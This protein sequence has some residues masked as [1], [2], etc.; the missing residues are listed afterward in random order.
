MKSFKE[1]L[2]ENDYP[3]YYWTQGMTR[4]VAYFK[5]KVE[6]DEYDRKHPNHDYIYRKENDKPDLSI[7]NVDNNI[8]QKLTKEEEAKLFEIPKT[9]EEQKKKIEKIDE[10]LKDLKN[11]YN[12]T[13]DKNQRNIIENLFNTYLLARESIQKEYDYWNK[14]D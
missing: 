9:A 6:K 13:N 7:L 11:K 5:N 12:N 8:L 1:Y 14:I 4:K 10:I 3:G 2:A